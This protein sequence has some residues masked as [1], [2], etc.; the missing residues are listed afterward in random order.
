M[1]LSVGWSVSTFKGCEGAVHFYWYV[2]RSIALVAVGLSLSPE[3]A[4]HLCRHHRLVWWSLF[5][6]TVLHLGE[7]VCYGL[8]LFG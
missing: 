5:S 7:G 4:K 3:M 1:K 8:R 2:A 6:L